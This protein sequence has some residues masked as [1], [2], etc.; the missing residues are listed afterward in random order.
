MT[1]KRGLSGIC[2]YHGRLPVFEKTHNK[3]C[4][5]NKR[6][7]DFLEMTLKGGIVILC[8]TTVT[9]QTFR[10]LTIMYV[11]SANIPL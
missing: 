8:P 6:F 9:F 2:P 10:R 5:D 3:V 4:T 7:L 11:W 1:L